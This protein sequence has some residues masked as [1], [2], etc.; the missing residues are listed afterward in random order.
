M[1]LVAPLQRF[2]E[3][4]GNLPVYDSYMLSFAFTLA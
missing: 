3:M 2:L 4:A 1:Q